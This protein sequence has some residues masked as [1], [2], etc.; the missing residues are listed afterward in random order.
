MASWRETFLNLPIDARRRYA[1][2]HCRQRIGPH[3]FG[4]LPSLPAG[5]APK[6]SKQE[7]LDFAIRHQV[8]TKD[9]MYT[10][11]HDFRHESPPSM[12]QLEY[13]FGSYGNFR[14]ELEN[15][16]RCWRW[17]RRIGD[18]ELVRYCARLRIRTSTQY[19]EIR[20]TSLGD[21]LPAYGTLVKRFGSWTL[22]RMLMLSYD[23]DTQ[24]NRYF[25]ESMRA[26]RELTLTECDRMG[27]EIRYLQETLTPALLKRIMHE[28]EML[29]RNP[30][31]G[32]SRGKAHED[33]EYHK[34][35][36]REAVSA[37]SAAS[38]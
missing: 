28:K 19:C 5:S 9:E 31:G 26:G 34:K 24:M 27:I 4:R 37:P 3:R 14:R 32:I 6:H 33:T 35:R 30:G 36:T 18:E 11:M 12:T 17:S 1:G 7:I 8:V 10:A 29:F 15:D 16:P 2:L 23:I 22:F 38:D 21:F 13:M 20:K 25:S